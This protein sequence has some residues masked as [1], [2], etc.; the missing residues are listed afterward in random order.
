MSHLK[1]ASLALAL[2]SATCHAE[3]GTVLAAPGGRYVLG[4]ISSARLDQYVLDTQTG[5][6]WQMQCAKKAADGIGCES[7]LFVPIAFQWTGG[8]PDSYGFTPSWPTTNLAAP[9]TPAVKK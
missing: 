2:F 3:P 5:K 4:Q 8:A 6:V 9:A 1:I 7:A